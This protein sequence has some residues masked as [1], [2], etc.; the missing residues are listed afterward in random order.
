MICVVCF[1]Q[2]VVYSNYLSCY[3][4]FNQAPFRCSSLNFKISSQTEM[5]P[6]WNFTE[7]EYWIDVLKFASF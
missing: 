4:S 7:L 3:V 6:V 1:I 5:K 2:F